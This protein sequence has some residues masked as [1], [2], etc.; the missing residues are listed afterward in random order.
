MAVHK[1][2]KRIQCKK[3]S[4]KISSKKLSSKKKRQPKKPSLDAMAVY[5]RIYL[6]DN[7][8]TILVYQT[9]G[10]CRLVYN[11]LVADYNEKHE[12]FLKEQK[13]N[14]TDKKFKYGLK[15]ANELLNEL[16]KEEA[17][18]FLKNVHS[19]ILQQAVLNFTTALSNHINYPDVFAQ[20]TF[21]KKS[22]HRDSFRIPIDAI[23]GSRTKEGI[24]CV[25]GNR[26]SL[27]SKLQNILFKCSRRDEKYI[28]KHQKEIRS[29]TVSIAPDGKMYAS[30]LVTAQEV[31][32][33]V[34]DMLCTFDLGLIEQTIE[35]HEHI[36]VDD[37]GFVSKEG[38]EVEY[39]HMPNLNNHKEE[40]EKEREYNKKGQTRIKHLEKKLKHLQRIL[41]RTEYDVKNH[42]TQRNK[43]RENKKFP[44]EE[45]LKKKR[46]RNL[47]K[48]KLKRA[49]TKPFDKNKKPKVKQKKVS[50]NKRPE[51]QK[52]S[53]RH[54]KIRK[55]AAK[56][57]AKIANIR[58]DY[59]HKISTR[60]V[61]E[62]Q[63]I[64]SE[65]LN[66]KGMV[67]NHKLAKAISNAGW[68]QLTDF[69]SYKAQRYGRIYFKVDTFFASSKTCP[70]CGHKN[71]KLTLKDRIW[72]CPNC[73]EIISRD[74]GATDNMSVEGVEKYNI[75]H[76]T[77][78]DEQ[79]KGES[80][81]SN[82]LIPASEFKET[83]RGDS[84]FENGPA[85]EIR[86]DAVSNKLPMKR[87]QK[88]NVEIQ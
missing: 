53:N 57:A 10:C 40:N 12:A 60:I 8:E 2:H 18:S 59:N 45:F 79:Y 58:K 33:E 5:L 61:R 30:V 83:G 29:I 14:K 87:L 1:H 51:W 81:S 74:E 76:R 27:C 84:L 32:P 73:H 42:T 48:Y 43:D 65:D 70:H 16:K 7:D 86:Q 37:E 54:E 64:V 72:E 82:K 25:I 78:L 31:S 19:K 49:T 35:R 41:S 66:V 77:E 4:L 36:F 67:K 9:A 46:E 11:K 26:I 39:V 44:I 24:K 15:E 52:S 21:K 68:R 23:P 63:M 71:K 80:D 69:I 56:V 50:E 55:Q 17:Y 20:P 3:K 47:A 88:V 28:N 34:V 13:E 38:N 6:N 62:N 75:R 22:T 85:G